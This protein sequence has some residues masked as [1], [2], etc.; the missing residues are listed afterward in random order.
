MKKCEVDP[1]HPT[2]DWG[3]IEC[4]LLKLLK[5]IKETKDEMRTSSE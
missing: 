2:D 3:C 1:K 5:G 4:R